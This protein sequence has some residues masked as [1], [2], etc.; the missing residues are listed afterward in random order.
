MGYGVYSLSILAILSIVF[1][2]LVCFWGYRI[3]R[4]VLGILGFI[5][6]AYV[7]GALAFHLSGGSYIITFVAG[8][9]GGVIGAV[10]IG[11][12]YY[13]GVFVLGALAA[14]TFGS[15]MVA[16]GG[17]SMPVVLIIVLAIIGG[18]LTVIFQK[19]VIVLS[20]A[21]IGSW[22]IITGI[23]YFFSG[24]FYSI[25]LFKYPGSLVR[26]GGIRFYI[27]FLFWIVLAVLGILNQYRQIRRTKR[28]RIE[29]GT[30]G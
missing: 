21:I 16:A 3:F 9:I 7:V 22:G 19:L 29:P 23:I 17:H 11:V 13:I 2:I 5:L 24:G 6:G 1:G 30:G 15:F 14:I 8:L 12:V 28:Q 10:L 26:F 25:S 20:T 18:V 27:V 4:I